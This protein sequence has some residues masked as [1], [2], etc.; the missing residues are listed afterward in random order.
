MPTSCLPR[1]LVLGV[2]ALAAGCAGPRPRPVV[3]G[4]LAP[5]SDVVFVAD[6]SGDYRTTSIALCQAIHEQAVPLRIETFVW[7]HGYR[8]LL[9]D[10]VDHCNH[11]EQGRRLAAR[12]A[13]S[14]PGCPEHAIYLV[15]HSSGSAVVLAAAET[16][17][18][19]SIERI[20]L[21]APAV[22]R[23]YDLRPALREPAGHRR[24]R[25]SA[26]R[27]GLGPRHEYHRHGR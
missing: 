5:E 15:G 4:S 10:H 11:V 13:A 18:P 14:Y 27:G 23:H 16:L 21:L 17:P 12:I 22:S 25:Q 8:R 19:G 7:S 24:V 1:L 3:C 26:R 2:L 9:T 20:V 6:G